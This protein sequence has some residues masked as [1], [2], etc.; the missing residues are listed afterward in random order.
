MNQQLISRYLTIIG[1]SDKADDVVIRDELS[2]RH[3]HEIDIENT[4]CILRGGQTVILNDL[5][6][7]SSSEN[8]TDFYR[9]PRPRPETI[10]AWLGVPISIP[11]TDDLFGEESDRKI[12]IREVFMIIF[13][14][15]LAT[16]VSFLVVSP[17]VYD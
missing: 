3:W 11:V 7:S 2:K 15:I 5:D 13:L 4:L 9:S 1:V 16:L 8:P 10:S 6:Q 17:L 14:I 12:L